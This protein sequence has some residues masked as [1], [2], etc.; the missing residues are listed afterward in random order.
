[1]TNDILWDKCQDYLHTLPENRVYNKIVHL[2]V[3]HTAKCIN[4]LCK[5]RRML[6]WSYFTL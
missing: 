5:Q 1:M 3:Y 4:Q 2:Y 6:H